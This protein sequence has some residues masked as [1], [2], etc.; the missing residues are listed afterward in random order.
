MKSEVMKG[1]SPVA[2]LTDSERCKD[3]VVDKDVNL[4]IEKYQAENS[5]DRTSK[6]IRDLN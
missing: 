1:I 6:Q 4:L 5:L 2:P 3:I